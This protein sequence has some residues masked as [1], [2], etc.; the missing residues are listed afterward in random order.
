[1]DQAPY[2][3]DVADG[4]E[5]AHAQ[6]VHARDGVRLRVVFWPLDTAKGTVFILPG[7]TECAE[8]YARGARDLAALGYASLAIDWRGQGLADRLL[9]DPNT[10]HV[11]T[12]ADYQKDL[13]AVMAAAEAQNM[14]RPWFII[15]HSMGGCIGLRTLMGHHP[16]AA[17]GFSAPMW[18]IGLKLWQKVLALVFGPIITA[19]GL[20]HLRA[21]G[22]KAQTYMLWH[23]FKDNLLTS[24]AD[25][26]DYMTRQIKTY[27]DLGLGGP[28][29]QWVREA[30]AETTA[31]EA[32]PSPD[33]PVLTF[34]G[35]DE[36]IVKT[37][38]VRARMAQWPAGQLVE[39][40]GGRH[41]IPMETPATRA[42]FYGRLAELFDS[43]TRA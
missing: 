20:A 24:D 19:V 30:I 27:P 2:F 37:A 43:I 10:G 17:A 38:K 4:P 32:L 5:V 7:R 33:V 40:A 16:F 3:A 9:T 42:Q 35:T 29:T 15:G 11:G 12:F 21:V 13:R 6:W 1:M 26:Y 39:V 41:E 28:S 31:L 22:T 18:G 25:M 8:K 14:P 34:L 36:K 23:G